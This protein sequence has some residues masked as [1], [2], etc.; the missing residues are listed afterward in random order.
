[1]RTFQTVVLLIFGA[2]ALLGVFIF[3][4]VNSGGSSGIGQVE[5][6]GTI[7]QEDF[8]ALIA[9]VQ[10]ERKDFD[11]VRYTEIEPT[12]YKKRL[13]ESFASG[14]GPD[15]YLVSQDQVLS[16]TPRILPISYDI[17]SV[18]DFKDAFIE[19]GEL[20]LI[21]AGILGLPLTIDPLLMY[22]NRD[23]LSQAGIAQP[24][25]FWD[26]LV[27]LAPKLTVRD[28]KGNI[29]RSTI[30]FGEYRNVTNAKEIL[31]TL[32]LQAGDPIVERDA[33]GKPFVVID[34]EATSLTAPGPSTLR[35]YTEF[36][37]PIKT[38]YSWNRAL[39]TSQ[40][41][42]LA[43]DLAL[44]IGFASELSD[45]RAQNPNLNFDLAPLPQ[46]RDLKNKLTFGVMQALSVSKTSRNPGGAQSAALILT[47][48]VEIEVLAAKLG[49]PPVTRTGLANRPTGGASQLFYDS[50]LIA[51]GWLDPNPES[52]N[53]IFLNMIEAVTSGKL[54]ISDALG[55][56]G[57]AL[58]ELLRGN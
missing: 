26:E 10:S 5:I 58:A 8:D 31:A 21:D 7:P 42:F 54:E 28:G 41:E 33:E 39:P 29:S 11:Q 6:W 3:A 51:R 36:A 12:I 46:T 30:A 20:Y 22:W 45:L 4:T 34:R 43:G 49:L 18:R 57:T 16:E 24:P 50:A 27:A 14:A 15:L 47:G 44:Y 19:E 17:L 13:L 53:E 55:R 48:D 35:F 38:I 25:K 2:L 37:N 56:A 52:S 32:F 40:K 1:M 9:T 23:I